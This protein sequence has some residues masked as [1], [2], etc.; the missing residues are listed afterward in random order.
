M[1]NIRKIL[2]IA[3]SMIIIL[4]AVPPTFVSSSA[5]DG[6]DEK[7]IIAP[8]DVLECYID[9]G[10]TV[11]F[12]F[13]P[14]TSDYYYF[15]SDAAEDTYGYIYG[16]DFETIDYDDDSGGD[17]MFLL[18]HFFEAG[19]EY[20]LGI[21]FYDSEMQGTAFVGLTAEFTTTHDD[22]REVI[23]EPGCTNEGNAETVCM[24]CG[25]VIPEIIPAT[26]HDFEGDI[27]KNCG[28]RKMLIFLGD[29]V[30]A[31]NVSD[32]KI[33]YYMFVPETSGNY[34]FFSD[35]CEDTVG[36]IADEGFSI[37]TESDDDGDE[38][39]FLIY[40][41][42]IAGQTYYLGIRYYYDIQDGTDTY[43]G[44]VSEFTSCHNFEREIT[45]EPTCTKT[46]Y[47]VTACTRCG[48]EI[49]TENL[50][51]LGHDFV[52]G[53]CTR[54]QFPEF[55]SHSETEIV[56]QSDP[57]CENEGYTGDTVCKICGEYIS[58]GR[59]LPRHFLTKEAV[60]VV[61]PT[62]LKEGYTV[63]RCTKCGEEFIYD[64]TFK[65]HTK[66][67]LIKRYNPTC[68]R[69]GWSVYRCTECSHQFSTDWRDALGHSL[70]EIRTVEAPCGGRGYTL[71]K[72]DRCHNFVRD[73]Y[74]DILEHDFHD[75]VCTRCSS[76]MPELELNEFISVEIDDPG[77]QEYF[78][79]TPETAGTY[80]FYS[81]AQGDT[82]GCLYDSEMNVIENSDDAHYEYDGESCSSSDFLITCE[83][84]AGETY[85]FSA[86][87]YNNEYGTGEF[88][89]RLTDDFT[90]IHNFVCS[91]TVDPTCL[92]S[93]FDI[94]ECSVCGLKEFRNNTDPLGDAHIYEDGVCTRCGQ[95]HGITPREGS[96]CVID[97]E[98]K[99]IYGLAPFMNTGD[100][101]ENY[102]QSSDDTY[103]MCDI[104][105]GT[106]AKVFVFDV[107]SRDV[108]DEYTILLYGDVN[109]DGI[110]DGEDAMIVNCL[111]NG[112]ILPDQ[113]DP[114][115]YSA[116]DCNHDGEI[117]S[118][119][120]LILEQAGVMLA[121][122]DQTKDDYAE[123]DAFAEY[124]NLIDQSPDT[125]ELIENPVEEPAISSPQTF[126][127]KL[128]GILQKVIFFIYSVFSKI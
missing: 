48:Y 51:A 46:G 58:S 22:V 30:K 37:I 91:Q 107:E 80:S 55:C 33:T 27:C 86:R 97:K 47:A 87:F 115:C 116:A 1:K 66:G 14:E 88:V 64:W 127:A 9:K 72:C 74:T 123:T 101:H 119:D 56:N 83:L 113:M 85:Y 8:G 5:A 26:G 70:T 7:E 39:N 23:T 102:V 57:T 81:D 93:G 52:D 96:G 104:V 17:G 110:Y 44:L 16:S 124:L 29:V 2:S 117:D 89:V 69:E 122:V 19:S 34:A 42:F 67:E 77:E 43:I 128:L 103:I 71:Y 109:R 62:C 3:L 41:D 126:L 6:G 61:E 78:S 75:G 118:S 24:R 49:E 40:Y 45:E 79:F 65:E 53:F 25:R 76:V 13:A 20:Y 54:C 36:F 50:S 31:D 38:S 32:D 18:N 11:Y 68:E 21:R 114:L 121:N 111:A 106:G 10:E 120:V 112:L 105:L 84:E 12:R 73:D 28:E 99:L 4:C 82:V 100:I 92:E 15:F 98:N 60:N 94:Y 95:I 63:Y 35:S 59:Y 108:I 125:E 90:K